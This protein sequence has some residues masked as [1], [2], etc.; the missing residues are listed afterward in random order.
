VTGAEHD[1][2]QDSAAAYVLGA[3]PEDERNGYEAHLAGCAVCR[4]EVEQLAPAA[5]AL[6]ASVEPMAPP[7]E[8][9]SRI[10]AEVEREAVLLAAAGPAADRAAAEP[11]PRRRRRER[12]GWARPRL[13][14]APVAA[15]AAVL[16]VGVA[17]GFGIAGLG[18]SGRTVTAQVDAARAPGAGAQIEV[19]D[20]AATLTAHGLPAPPSGR[21]YQVWLKRP[22]RAPEPTS[23]L[24]SPSRD[25]TATATVP[26]SLDGID[27]VLV[28]DEP[29]G[30]SRMPTREPLVVA[31]L[32]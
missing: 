7:P 15:A 6:P 3:L 28:T 5:E 24:F 31:S 17:I 9:K 1:R 8:L 18:D 23:A 21:V 10:M 25:G 26:G 20:G 13:A 11:A 12:F 29:M 19:E 16:V 4:E 30:G 27:Q 14:L 32:S 2:W 22:G